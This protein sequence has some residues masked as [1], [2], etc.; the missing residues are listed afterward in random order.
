MYGL[1]EFQNKEQSELGKVNPGQL[2][3]GNDLWSLMF[4]RGRVKILIRFLHTAT[5]SSRGFIESKLHNPPQTCICLV[6]VTLRVW[7]VTVKFRESGSRVL[8][9]PVV[10]WGLSYNLPSS[11]PGQGLFC[12]NFGFGRLC[13]PSELCA[14]DNSAV[15]AV[16]LWLG[17]RFLFSFFSSSSFW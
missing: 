4:K 13:S 7:T 10:T 2:F 16:Q 14:L 5:L 9:V 11:W 12:S 8:V 3:G 15:T 6:L 1:K 17:S